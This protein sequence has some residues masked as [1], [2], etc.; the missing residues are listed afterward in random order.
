VVLRDDSE[1][2]KLETQLQQAQKMEAIGT[3][4]GGI[5]HDFNNI[6]AG[7]MGYTEL[8]LLDTPEGNR[9]SQNL[10]QVLKSGNRAKD[11][12][13]QIL[14]FGRKTDADRKPLEVGPIVKESLKLLR[15]SLP[16]TIE[17]NHNIPGNLGKVLADPTQ[18]HQV[19]MNLCTNAA[20]AMQ[21]SGGILEVSL[22]D[23]EFDKDRALQNLGLPAGPYLQLTVKD[24][25]S[26][27]TPEVMERIFDPYF[28]TKEKGGGT[29]LGLA[30][31]HGITRD[32]R[33]AISVQ[34][35]QGKGSTFD[36]Y[37]PVIRKDEIPHESVEEPLPK[38][39]ERALFIDDE[40][41]LAEIGKEML[42]RLGYK[43][44]AKTNSLD[45]LEFFR[46]DPDQFD[47]VITDMTMPQMTGE[48]LA[49]NLMSIR[50]DIPVILCT[51]Y[52]EMMTEEKAKEMGIKGFAMKPLI[53]RDLAS[54]IRK[55]LDKD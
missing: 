11:L 19:L 42:T 8:A 34:S 27:M 13:K 10:K 41:S 55:V 30:V 48:K 20:H 47:L 37:L 49:Q 14:A 33:G 50:P 1:R 12:V 23:I 35:E 22:A 5:A 51:G 24:T 52:S 40:Q 54:S 45:A 18:I 2:K 15:A 3:L 17:F 4:A 16:T 53:I 25:G 46:T 6:L 26:G 28:T 7:I 31:V 38:G 29:G 21:K 39:H 9:A 36:V 44:V 32:H 43:V